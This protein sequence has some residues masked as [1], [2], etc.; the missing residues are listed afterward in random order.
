M[1]ER[2]I[3]IN[4]DN[5]DT[6]ENGELAVKKAKEVDYDLIMM[7]LNMPVMDGFKATQLIKASGKKPYIVALSA[8]ILTQP[9]RQRCRNEV[10]DDQ[11]MVRVGVWTHAPAW[12][13]KEFTASKKFRFAFLH[14]K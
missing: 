10:F 1:F 3:G 7:D 14:G 9:L 4:P 12:V 8:S 6:A 11:F 2:S 5:I 13:W